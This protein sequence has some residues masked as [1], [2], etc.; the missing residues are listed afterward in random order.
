[1]PNN[2]VQS[3]RA[4]VDNGDRSRQIFGVGEDQLRKLCQNDDGI[5]KALIL[6]FRKATGLVF[7]EVVQNADVCGALAGEVLDAE[8][9][10]ASHIRCAQRGFHIGTVTD[11]G[12]TGGYF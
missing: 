2:A 11:R 7:H 5:V 10:I 6:L 12:D 1:M 3:G 9:L 8:Q 4:V